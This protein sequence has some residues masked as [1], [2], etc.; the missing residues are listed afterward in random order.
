MKQ[1]V[2]LLVLLAFTNSLTPNKLKGSHSSL[3][4]I[5]NGFFAEGGLEKPKTLMNCFDDETG[6]LTFH[7]FATL[8]KQMSSSNVVA[9]QKTV[10]LYESLLPK[11]F[12]ECINNDEDMKA[13]RKAYGLPNTL[14]LLETKVLAFA[15]YN[16][17]IFRQFSAMLDM[18]YYNGK[19]EQ[20]GH[21]SGAFAKKIF[22]KADS[23][24]ATENK[25]ILNSFLRGLLHEK[26][27]SASDLIVECFD[28]ENAAIAVSF[29]GN[30]YSEVAHYS[31]KTFEILT[32]NMISKLSPKVSECVVQH[33]QMN[34]IFSRISRSSSTEVV[35]TLANYIAGNAEELHIEQV[36]TK[37]ESTS[38]FYT[39]LGQ[40]FAISLEK[41]F[42]V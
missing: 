35:S 37:T 40:F 41:S 7:F 24:T 15:I 33:K 13:A 4:L 29:I 12:N 23:E 27:P 20:L 9:I 11:E 5:F 31:L 3:T 42:S 34:E 2:F 16:P 25:I 10:S 22:N 17:P 18:T 36:L 26:D 14:K 8:F 19:F 30:L 1:F 6:P 38:S 28:N 32:N 21:I 39:A